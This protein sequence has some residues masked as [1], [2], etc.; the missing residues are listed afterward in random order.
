[1]KAAGHNVGLSHDCR[2]VFV[3]CYL[4]LTLILY[5]TDISIFQNMVIANIIDCRLFMVLQKEE[6]PY[7]LKELEHA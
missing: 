7:L 4:L 6:G 1:M 5:F 2:L 3:F